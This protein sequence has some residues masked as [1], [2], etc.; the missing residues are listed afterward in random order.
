MA[1]LAISTRVSCSVVQANSF[2]P[3]LVGGYGTA[4]VDV[5]LRGAAENL[6]FCVESRKTR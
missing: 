4:D 6:A 5:W 1:G 2:P 3:P